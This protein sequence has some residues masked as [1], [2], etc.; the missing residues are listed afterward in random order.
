MTQR[1]AFVSSLILENN[2]NQYLLIQRPISKPFPHYWEFPGGKIEPKETPVDALNRELHE[3]IGICVAPE[4]LTPITFASYPYPG[5]YCTILYFHSKKWTG[6]IVL[7]EEQPTYGWFTLEE[8]KTLSMPDANYILFE[9]LQNNC[10]VG[11]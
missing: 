9:N 7:K 5:I 6:E 10:F 11:E 2:E 4:D 1:Y 3:E 8:M